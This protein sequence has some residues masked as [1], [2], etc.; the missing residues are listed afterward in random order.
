M[1]KNQ[2]ISQSLDLSNYRFGSPQR[3]GRMTV[4]PLFGPNRDS[5]F[6]APLTG[7]KLSG[8]EGYGEVEMQNRSGNGGGVAIVPLHIGYIQD[9]AQNHALCRSAFI[10]PGQKLVFRDACCVQESQG[11][12]LNAAEQWFFILPLS[13]REEALRLRGTEGYGKLWKA[14]SQLN[15]E[16]GLP[17]RGHL[18]QV[19]CRQRSYLTQYAGRFELLT[20]QTGAMFF[21]HNTLVG[22][23]VAPNAQYFAEL[24]SP[25]VCFCYGVA[26]MQEDRKNGKAETEV[27]EPFAAASLEELKKELAQSRQTFRR[28][29][30]HTLENMPTERFEIEEE[31]RFLD[32]NLSTTIGRNYAGQ[33]V[34]QNDRL[35][36][37]SVFARKHVLRN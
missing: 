20:G 21:L 34:Q 18:E 17:E 2:M 4:L 24:W 32:L 16:M 23:E 27:T 9:R 30:F 19:I 5:R 12:Y 1:D 35:V 26:A 22:V 13:L 33:I 29:L 25:L 6:A 15:I 8:V 36:Y 14:I 3:S 11:G 37:A 28:Q 10:A 31:E 7:L